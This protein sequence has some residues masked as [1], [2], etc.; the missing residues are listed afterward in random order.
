MLRASYGR[1]SQGVLT[2]EI[3]MFHPAVTPIRTSAFVAATGGYTQ[4]VSVVDSRINL[5]IDANTRAP[6]TDEL[7]V[8]VDREVGRRLAVA[9]AYVRK[10]GAKFIGLTDTAGQV[11]S[12]TRTPADGRSV[13]HLVPVTELAT[14][15]AARL[16]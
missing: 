10:D 3:G 11:R 4:L 7:S 14:S 2:G 5:K 15:L 12:A 9:V 6:R 13:P 16:R 8:G 1:F